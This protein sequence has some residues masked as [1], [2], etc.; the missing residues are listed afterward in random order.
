M[1]L[2]A[3]CW[4]LVVQFNLVSFYAEKVGPPFICM[5]AYVALITPEEEIE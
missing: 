4:R 3:C 2:F 1:Q 5:F